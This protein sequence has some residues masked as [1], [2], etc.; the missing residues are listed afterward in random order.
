MV[1]MNTTNRSVVF[2]KRIDQSSH[3]IIPELDGASVQTGENPWSFRVKAQTS[4]LVATGLEL[5]QHN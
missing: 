2:L 5:G 3:T 4:N 1:K